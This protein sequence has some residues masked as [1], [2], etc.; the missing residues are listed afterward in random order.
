MYQRLAQVPLTYYLS[1]KILQEDIVDHVCIDQLAGS[2]SGRKFL[3][4]QN[5]E[6]LPE[7]HILWLKL[8]IGTFK[9]FT[10]L[11]Q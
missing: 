10:S 2:L 6:R 4:C 1:L 3:S 11:S 5:N 9:N 7:Q 8:F